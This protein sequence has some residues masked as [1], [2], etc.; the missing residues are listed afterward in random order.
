MSEVPTVCP[1][2]YDFA[3]YLKD[4]AKEVLEVEDIPDRVTCDEEL[5]IG[6]DS[7]FR[8][9]KKEAFLSASC[10]GQYCN[11]RG[12]FRT[13]PNKIY[14]IIEKYADKF[15][16]ERIKRE[17]R[18]YRRYGEKYIPPFFVLQKDGLTLRVVGST[19]IFEPITMLEHVLRQSYGR[20][21]KIIVETGCKYEDLDKAI[22]TVVDTLREFVQTK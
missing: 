3:K 16:S 8:I 13:S 22:K 17:I 19:I 18:A 5:T 9:D 2:V 20:L 6:V 7:K 14:K 10:K 12:F 21:D 11:V 4:L 15:E 1:F